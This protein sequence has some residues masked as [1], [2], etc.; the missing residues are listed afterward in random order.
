MKRMIVAM[1]AVLML[2]GQSAFAAEGHSFR[3]SAGPSLFYDSMSQEAGAGGYLNVGYRVAPSVDLDVYGAVTSD[4][5]VDNDLTRGDASVSM[6]TLGARYL[7]SMGDNS[8]GYIAAGI[9]VLKLEA[10]EVAPGTD[11]SR[12]GG[13]ARFGV[14]VDVP[15]TDHLGL[16]CGAGF[17]R[18]LGST[19]EITLFDL[20]TALFCT[21]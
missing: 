6:L 20:S 2:L 19:D 1:T 11:D 14:G 10:D 4:F 12:T 13:V 21:F 8:T 15:L 7:S 16:T 9:G 18:G 5:E 3:I 17:S